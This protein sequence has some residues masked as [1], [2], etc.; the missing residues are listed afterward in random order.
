MIAL[1]AAMSLAYAPPAD[2]GDGWTVGHAADVGMDPA[3]LDAMVA[4]LDADR[5]GLVHTVHV[6]RHGRLVLEAADRPGRLDVPHDLRSATKSLTGLLVLD[7]V[8]RGELR[9]DDPVVAH[10]DLAPP[11]DPRWRAVTVDHLLTMRSGLDC[12]DRDRRTPGWE[13]RMYR[14]RDWLAFW[15][16]VPF[17]RDPGT[18]AHYCTGNVVALGRVLEGATGR[19]FREVAAERLLAPLHVADAAWATYDRGERTDTGGHLRL[20]AR[21]LAKVGQLV[22][23][24]GRWGGVQVLDPSVVDGALTH[25]TT[26]DGGAGYGRLWWHGAAEMAGARHEVWFASGNGGQLV[27]VVPD[28]DLTATF[29]GGAFDRPEARI[30]FAFLG[31]YVLAAVVDTA[32]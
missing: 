1:L 26:L 2:R 10:L 20:R 8:H 23:D 16:A 14:R 6:A 27:F 5:W 3:V 28:L 25:Q 7:A 22:L 4:A 21:D 32:R 9:L 19:P 17:A 13:D 31:G 15:L 18:E 11:P 12:D 29:T 30:P 24:R